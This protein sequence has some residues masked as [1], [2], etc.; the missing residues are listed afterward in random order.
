MNIYLLRHT[1]PDVPPNTCYGQSD[2]GITEEDF[3]LHLEKLQPIL[4]MDQVQTIYTSPLHRCDKLAS[5]LHQPGINYIIDPRLKEINFGDWEMQSWSEIDGQ[6][7]VEWKRDFRHAPS[8]KG[9]SH[10]DLYQR[11]KA[12]WQDLI[13]RQ[14]TQVLVVTHGGVLKS[15]LSLILEMPLEKSYTIKLHYGALIY[16]EIQQIAAQRV[17]FLI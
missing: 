2:I 10:M 3:R 6:E 7:L 5:S 8:P 1:K 4:P 16:I 17:D 13:R 12:F 11:A 9:E 14:E 15:L